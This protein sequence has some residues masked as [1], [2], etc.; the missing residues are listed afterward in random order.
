MR[1]TTETR[2]QITAWTLV[3]AQAALIVGLL[4]IPT[5]H[6]WPTPRGLQWL[7]TTATVLG[8]IGMILAGLRL[9]RGLTASPLP[10]QAAQ[11]RTTGP[12]SYV[13]H[14]IYTALLTF[15][16]GQVIASGSL[17]RLMLLLVL[18]ALLNAKAR[19]EEK[20]LAARFPDYPAYAAGVPRFLPLPTRRRVG[21]RPNRTRMPR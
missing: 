21:S 17:P 14:P 13:R 16:V 3:L 6:S 10:N 19:W 11:L 1:P 5:G 2:R 7:S 8:C 12:Y 18:I 20:Q 15:G 9:G 4:L